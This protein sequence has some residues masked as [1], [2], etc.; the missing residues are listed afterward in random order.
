M[1]S[2]SIDR[3]EVEN[4]L[5]NLLVSNK[6]YCFSSVKVLFGPEVQRGV[7]QT[8]FLLPDK[9]T[10][11]TSLSRVRLELFRCVRVQWLSASVDSQLSQTK[12]RWPFVEQHHSLAAK[13]NYRR[14]RIPP[15]SALP[16]AWCSI[17]EQ[18]KQ[19]LFCSTLP[20]L[21]DS[22]SFGMKRV[23]TGFRPEGYSDRPIQQKHVA[24]WQKFTRQ[25]R[26]SILLTRALPLFPLLFLN[27]SLDLTSENRRKRERIYSLL[28]FQTGGLFSK[29]ANYIL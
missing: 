26:N 15:D 24:Q 17:E 2:R 11:T 3:W 29:R 16:I 25:I 19:A 4:S 22:R 23:L 21:T 13:T 12:T 27:I 5:N 9:K 20:S 6:K 18:E 28:L 14:Q 7:S 8:F 10:M 1:R